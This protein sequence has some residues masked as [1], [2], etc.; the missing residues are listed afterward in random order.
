MVQ[1]TRG[2]RALEL[3]LLQDGLEVL[4]ALLGV[5][6]VRRQVAVEEAERVSEHGH[7]GADAALVPL[8]G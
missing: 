5:L 4:H 8:G 2:G 3:L 6:H 7:P 1:H